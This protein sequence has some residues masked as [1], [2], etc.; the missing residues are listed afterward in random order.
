MP[1]VGKVKIV[2][3]SGIQSGV[4]MKLFKAAVILSVLAGIGGALGADAPKAN[5]QQTMLT[6]VNPNALALW[7]ITNNAIDDNGDVAASKLKAADWAKLLEI[8]KALEEGGKTLATSSGIIAATP[9]AKLDDESDAGASKAADVQRYIDAKPATFRS[10]ALEL[11][12]SGVGVVE[13]AKKHDA[14]RLNN[15]AN[16]LDEV[17]EQCHVIFWYPQQKK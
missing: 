15:L 17:C 2:V 8:G 3:R 12:K 6:K 4:T 10:H 11:Q 1:P 13:A 5:L 14:K 9:G 7:A 16:S